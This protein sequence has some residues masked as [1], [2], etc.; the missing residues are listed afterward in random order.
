MI[1]AT[2][3]HPVARIE[4]LR[5]AP[6][7]ATLLGEPVVLWRDGRAVVHAWADRCPHRGARLSLG[8]VR[9]G[10]LEC[11]YHG[12]RFAGSGPAVDQVV[13]QVVGQV[14]VVPAL[15]GFT[16]PSTHRATVFACTERYGLVWVRLAADGVSG[17]TEGAQV[18][19]AVRQAL[20]DV[21]ERKRE[22]ERLAQERV[23]REQEIQVVG[24]EQERIRQNM[25]QLDRGGDL[26][27]RY[28]QKFTQQED[29][30]E[31]LRKEIA[32]VQRQEQE[33][34]Q[35]LDAMLAKLEI[36]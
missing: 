26:Y 2:H 14:V 27:T 10:Q 18:S 22:I 21:I 12:W 7:A 31:S 20:A 23:K 36:D 1:E 15:P 8:C 24:Q 5:D 6:L 34:R 9:D 30:V 33:A 4:D 28:V 19:P 17:G 13:G 29:R 25:A 16:P 11:P 3:W 32:D 35:A